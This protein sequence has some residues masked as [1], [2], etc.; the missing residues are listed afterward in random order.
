MATAAGATVAALVGIWAAWRYSLVPKFSQEHEI[1]SGLERQG[2]KLEYR[3]DLLPGQGDA[4]LPLGS[5][6]YYLLGPENGPKVV[7]V[8]GIAFP[9]PSFKRIA[10]SLAEEK[11]CRVLVYDVYGRGYS[12]SPA[13]G[14]YTEGFFVA[15]MLMMLKHVGWDKEPIHVVGNSMGGAIV[16]SFSSHYPEMVKSLTLIAPAGLLPMPLLGRLLEIP[17]LGDILVTLFGQSLLLSFSSSMIDD[18]MITSITDPAEREA[19]REHV[20]CAR[21]TVHQTTLRSHAFLWA[22]VS[23]VRGGV[24]NNV[25]QHYRKLGDVLKDKNVTL[26]WGTKDVVVPFK[27]HT[28]VVE[29]I[30]HIDSVFFEGVG[31]EIMLTNYASCRNAIYN[32]IAKSL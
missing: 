8:H 11:S 19:V 7:L 21:R 20:E 6:R 3:S 10:R 28:K 17:L 22:Y 31:H 13:A 16:T 30:P 5:T 29:C 15:Q 23:T 24:L 12:V 1:L 14:S 9:S 18:D 32:T 4:P 26:V 2:E 25:E 27:L